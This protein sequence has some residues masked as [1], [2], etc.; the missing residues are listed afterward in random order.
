MILVNIVSQRKNNL[1]WKKQTYLASRNYT[2]EF[3][4]NSDILKLCTVLCGRNVNK[5][6][7]PTE[8]EG[9]GLKLRCDITVQQKTSWY[10]KLEQRLMIYG[11]LVNMENTTAVYS[12]STPCTLFPQKWCVA[13]EF[14]VL[15]SPGPLQYID[16]T[17]QIWRILVYI[18]L[19]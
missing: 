16:L 2:G 14:F 5:P 15:V 7:V 9:K 13:P 12:Y 6:S 17:H 1:N 10:I 4:L 18:F 19:V 8:V 11:F 3:S